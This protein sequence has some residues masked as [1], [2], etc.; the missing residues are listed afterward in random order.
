MAS[1]SM[2]PTASPGRS[3]RPSIS[4]KTSDS[5]HPLRRDSSSSNNIPAVP[6]APAAT[7]APTVTSLPRLLWSLQVPLH[8]T[9]ASQ[10][11][12]APFVTSV[13][14]FSYLAFLLPRLT[15]YFGA[16]C[17]SFHHEGILLRNLAVGL[18]VDLYQPE[19]RPWRLVVSDGPEWDIADTFTNAVKEADFVRNGNARQIMSLSKE[20]STALWNAVRDSKLLSSVPIHLAMVKGK[21]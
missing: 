7:A 8:I 13:P 3:S 4:R 21:E 18:L 20:H 19:T 12:A 9:H 10:P 16:P 1:P 5:D 6:V 2:S 17:S 14:R 15:V 11:D